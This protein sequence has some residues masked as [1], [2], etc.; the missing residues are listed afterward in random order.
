MLTVGL[1]LALFTAVLMQQTYG[2][3][4]GFQDGEGGSLSSSLPLL[5]AP[6]AVAVG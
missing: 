5:F 2:S 3:F 4:V 6:L 1:R